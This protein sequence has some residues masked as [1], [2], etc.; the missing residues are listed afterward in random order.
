MDELKVI[1]DMIG[2][3]GSEARFAFVAWLIAKYGGAF[4]LGMTAL[5]GAAFA[6]V[7]LIKALFA[8][9]RAHTIARAVAR[10][11]GE[12]YFNSENSDAVARCIA[13]VENQK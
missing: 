8:H 3:L 7:A 11:A 13:W 10:K 1:A 6:V 12:S 4:I 9:S 5:I 2:T